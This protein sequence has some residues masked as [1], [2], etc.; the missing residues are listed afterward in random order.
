MT[1]LECKKICKLLDINEIWLNDEGVVCIR[2]SKQEIGHIFIYEDNFSNALPL[3]VMKLSSKHSSPEKSL[4]ELLLKQSADGIKSAAVGL[5]SDSLHHFPGKRKLID[6]Y[7]SIE[8][9]LVQY[10]LKFSHKKTI[11]KSRY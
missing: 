4:L 3:R 8:S 10:D 1:D 7:E 2:T 9:L 6:A 11:K 5:L